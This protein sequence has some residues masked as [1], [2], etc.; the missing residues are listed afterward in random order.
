M[1]ITGNARQYAYEME[2]LANQLAAE[3]KD[4]PND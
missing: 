1:T 3:R 4:Q 2:R